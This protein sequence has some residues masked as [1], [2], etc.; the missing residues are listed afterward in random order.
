MVKIS[1]ALLLLLSSIQANAQVNFGNIINQVSTAVT[2]NSSKSAKGKKTATT[3]E[4]LGLGSVISNLTTVFDANK[5]ATAKQ[6]VGTWTYNEP[7]VVFKDHNW[8]K[9]AGGKLASAAIE[10]K[11]QTYLSRVGITKGAMKM[12]FKNDT[13]FTQTIGKKTVGGT[14]AINGKSVVLTYQ[15]GLK[16]MV[17]TTQV[18]GNSLL[19]VMDAGKLLKYAK[20]LGSLSGNATANTVGSLLSSYDGMEVGLRM[21]K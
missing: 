11:L 9:R 17:G 1:A 20:T 19:I 13:T 14:Y 12:T 18:D 16:Q 4:Q 2:A 10:K 3:M 15:G 5:T 8:L 6:L 21:M 7:A